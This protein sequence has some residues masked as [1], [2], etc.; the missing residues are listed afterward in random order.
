MAQGTWSA[1]RRIGME[2][3]ADGVGPEDSG[4]IQTVPSQLP[5]TISAAVA[6]MKKM[7]SP[8]SGRR[9]VATTMGSTKRK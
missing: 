7:I 6:T 1:R 8:T 4:R 3:G 5:T 2:T 9:P